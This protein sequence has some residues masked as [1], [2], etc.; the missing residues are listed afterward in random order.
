MAL[1]QCK[2]CKKEISDQVTN[3]PHC[4]AKLKSNYNKT[5]LICTGVGVIFNPFGI[6]SF[7]GL[8]CAIMSLAKGEN[9][10]G[11]T[12]ACLIMDIILLIFYFVISL[13]VVGKIMHI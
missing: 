13:G 12:I 2:E 4:G 8:I 5:A 6:L 10:K 3:C 11:W 7:I 9:N 1:V